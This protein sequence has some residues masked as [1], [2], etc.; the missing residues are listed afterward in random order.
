MM[1]SRNP[2]AMS[3]FCIRRLAI[4]CAPSDEIRTPTVAAVKITPVLIEL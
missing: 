2:P 1:F 3:R 4:R